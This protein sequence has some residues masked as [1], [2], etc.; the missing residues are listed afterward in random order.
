MMKSKI[1]ISDLRYRMTL[2]PITGY[3]DP[4]NGAPSQTFGPGQDIYCAAKLNTKAVIKDDKTY[5]VQEYSITV[6]RDDI[7]YKIQDKVTINGRTL[8]IRDIKDI[9]LWFQQLICTDEH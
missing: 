6:S 2:Y 8:Y 5:S 7:T 9:D 1:K 3:N 4:T